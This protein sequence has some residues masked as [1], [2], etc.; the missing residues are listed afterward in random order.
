MPGGTLDGLELCN[1]EHESVGIVDGVLID[2]PERRVR[3]FVVKRM[4]SDRVLIPVDEIAHV[5]S[6]ADIPHL[7][8]APDAQLLQFDP[9]T[10]RP[11]SADDAVTSMFGG[12]TS[13]AA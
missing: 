5:D 13:T 1:A 10:V 3:Y 11:F 6:E 8:A 4:P 9:C 7:E 2:P 12:S